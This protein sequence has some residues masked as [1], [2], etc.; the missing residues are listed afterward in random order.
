VGCSKPADDC[1]F[2]Y[3]NGD[4]NHHIGTGFFVQKG[5]IPAVKRVDFSSGRMSLV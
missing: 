2:F 5:I 1:T 4:A 3:G